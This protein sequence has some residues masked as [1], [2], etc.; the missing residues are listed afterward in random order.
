M[1][2]RFSLMTSI[3]REE[4]LYV[5]MSDWPFARRSSWV[6][7]VAERAAVNGLRA[8][9]EYCDFLEL[10]VDE[11]DGLSCASNCLSISRRYTKRL[12]SRRL[13]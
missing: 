3:S 6:G 9:D 2:S 8:E 12:K 5:S 10:L 7:F 1:Q 4:R 13:L 11:S